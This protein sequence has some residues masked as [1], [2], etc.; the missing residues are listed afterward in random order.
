MEPHPV[1][2]ELKIQGKPKMPGARP[3]GP[4]GRIGTIGGGVKMIGIIGHGPNLMTT[5]DQLPGQ[6]P[7]SS[8]FLSLYKVGFSCKMQDS[9]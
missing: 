5:K 2:K 6:L 4:D 8:Y 7:P 1:G 3:A 9:R